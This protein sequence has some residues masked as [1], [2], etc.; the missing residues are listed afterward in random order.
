MTSEIEPSPQLSGGGVPIVGLSKTAREL[1]DRSAKAFASQFVF[2]EEGSN[3][4]SI[5]SDI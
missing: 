5:I 4:L 3:K 2:L 1:S